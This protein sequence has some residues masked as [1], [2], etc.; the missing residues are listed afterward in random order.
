M[1]AKA[2]SPDSLCFAELFNHPLG[3]EKYLYV[4]AML[5]C[6]LGGGSRIYQVRVSVFCT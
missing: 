1:T 2:L 3:T 6:K 4:P 5:P